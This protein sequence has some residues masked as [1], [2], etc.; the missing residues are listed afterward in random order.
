M[1]STRPRVIFDKEGVCNACRHWENKKNINWDT[2]RDELRKLCDKYRSKDGSFDVI[3]PA[4]GGKDSS[5]VAWKLKHEFNMHPLC[6]SAKPP[7]S[8]SLGETNLKNFIKSGFN[9]IEINP[10]P[11]ICKKIDKEAFVKDGQPQA[12]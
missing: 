2:R 5:Y 12:G 10:N 7:L 1:P 4:G 11:E 9:L 3:V 6:V 8:T